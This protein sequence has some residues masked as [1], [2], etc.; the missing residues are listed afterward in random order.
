MAD[1]PQGR[2]AVSHVARAT[3]LLVGVVLLLTTA[4]GLGPQW[5]SQ[6]SPGA[7]SV[8]ASSEGS[9]QGLAR[10]SGALTS[11]SKAHVRLAAQGAAPDGSDY[12]GDCALLATL[13]P[14]PATTATQ[15]QPVPSARQSA[16][17]AAGLLSVRTPTGPPSA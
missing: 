10:T 5:S 1:Q 15:C 7:S 12:G 8:S 9:L 6:T 2:Q 16:H 11:P 3:S 14:L 17:A 13:L 4:V